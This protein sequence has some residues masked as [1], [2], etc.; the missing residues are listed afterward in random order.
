MIS[1]IVIFV[2]AFA[3]LGL[4]LGFAATFHVQPQHGITVAAGPGSNGTNSNSGVSNNNN[5]TSIALGDKVSVQVQP[6][7]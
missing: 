5:S 6:A 4:L 3:A 7:G 1:S 2:L